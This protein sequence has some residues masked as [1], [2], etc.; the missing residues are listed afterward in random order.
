MMT[1][2]E[3]RGRANDETHR[4]RIDDYFTLA[5]EFKATMS[6]PC[7]VWFV[8]VWDTVSSVGWV[9]N[10]LKLPFI[11]SNPDIQIGR[12]AVAIAERRAF[13]RS[14]LWRPS[15]D[16]AK[17]GPKD[18]KQV[19]FPGVHS[20]VGGGYAET[21]SGLSKL[22]LEWMIDEAAQKG[23]LVVPAKRD[24]I[25]GRRGGGRYVAPDPKASR[26][27]SLTRFW[28]LAEFLLRK[29]FDE[30]TG[31][32]RRRM[33]FYRRRT[34]PEGALVHHSVLQRGPVQLPKNHTII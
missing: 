34:I 6:R 18:L 33:N 4:Q 9:S 31:K 25:L 19:W 23:L 29:R 22:A 32:E 28:H 16:P 13:F 30:K 8:G 14:H 15:S 20:D 27:E 1:G 7:D 26:H 3:R 2:I 21:E 17:A 12:H 11:A 5:R 24:E 10:P